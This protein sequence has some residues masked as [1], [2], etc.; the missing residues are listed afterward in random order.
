VCV[1]GM[2][3]PLLLS[4]VVAHNWVNSPSRSSIVFPT[5]NP[6][7]CGA[8]SGQPHVQVIAGQMFQIEWVQGHATAPVYFGFYQ[9]PADGNEL[10]V[11]TQASSAVFDKYLLAAPAAQQ[12]SPTATFRQYTRQITN[13]LDYTGYQTGTFMPNYYVNATKSASY[14]IP[15]DPVFVGTFTNGTGGMGTNIT[16]PYQLFLP[17]AALANDRQVWYTNPSYPWIGVSRYY[18]A[19]PTPEQPNVAQFAFPL[20]TQPGVY[21]ANYLWSGYSDCVDIEIVAG[22][23]PVAHPYG[24]PVVMDNVTPFKF[25]KIPHCE[26]VD[27]GLGEQGYSVPCN[28]IY[29]NESGCLQACN[30]LTLQ[31]CAGINIVS[32]T[33]RAQAKFNVT[34]IPFSSNKSDTVCPRALFPSDPSPDFK[35]CYGVVQAA[36]STTGASYVVVNDPEDPR[37]ESTCYVKLPPSGLNSTAPPPPPPKLSWNFDS[38]CVDCGVAL[39]NNDAN[40]LPLWPV[41]DASQ[42]TNC[43]ERT[44]IVES[45]IGFDSSPSAPLPP[46]VMLVAAGMRCDGINGMWRNQPV[47]CA[48]GN[49]TVCM[50]TLLNL[51]KLF[52]SP[53]DTSFV[54]DAVAIALLNNKTC[55]QSPILVNVETTFATARNTNPAHSECATNV[56]TCCCS[57]S[58]R[59]ATKGT[60]IYSYTP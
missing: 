10:A 39:R 60:N 15:R 14:Y 27:P 1:R 32:I 36:P 3:F 9:M 53:V 54:A 28:Q 18:I 7:S 23:T 16:T 57:S 55:A 22:T 31:G 19:V 29:S 38:Y 45:N 41:L 20:G 46:G 17:D 35:V 59:Y 8:Y 30:R 24:L 56:D 40:F 43:D 50:Q 58:N 44:D 11:L 49:A 12:V 5:A 6:G 48:N 25:Q 42:C 13:S 4:F 2:I 47:G 21:V 33:N 51:G 34:S 37:F 26:F 52:T